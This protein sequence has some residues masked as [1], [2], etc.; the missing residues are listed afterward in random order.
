MKNKALFSSKDKSKKLKCCL[1]E[2]LF[3][4]LRVKE[5]VES[6]FSLGGGTRQGICEPLPACSSYDLRLN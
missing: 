4:V 5:L 1:L 2:F 3:G 6:M